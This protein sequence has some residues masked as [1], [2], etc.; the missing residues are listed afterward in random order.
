[1]VIGGSATK[2]T[3]ASKASQHAGERACRSG[4]RVSLKDFAQCVQ[5]FFNDE[6]QQ[7]VQNFAQD[8][9]NGSHDPS[10]DALFRHLSHLK[11]PYIRQEQRSG[12][13]ANQ[14]LVSERGSKQGGQA[15]Q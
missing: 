8:Y 3:Q 7:S 14:R 15:S 4:H 5:A 10:L 9:S 1:L 2:W 13:S 11:L 6:S 12:W